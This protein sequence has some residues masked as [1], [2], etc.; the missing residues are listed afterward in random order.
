MKEGIRIYGNFIFD[1]YKLSLENLDVLRNKYVIADIICENDYYLSLFLRK[2]GLISKETFKYLDEGKK[3]TLVYDWFNDTFMISINI[4]DA[5]STIIDVCGIFH[6]QLNKLVEKETPFVTAEEY[7]VAKR[8]VSELSPENLDSANNIYD[9]V[10]NEK[11][12]IIDGFLN[13]DPEMYIDLGIY[14]NMEE[15]YKDLYRNNNEDPAYVEV[16]Y[17]YRTRFMKL[18]FGR[19]FS[20]NECCLNIFCDK[21]INYLSDLMQ[22]A[23]KSQFGYEY[24][25][26]IFGYLEEI[27]N[28]YK[29]IEEHENII[30]Q[31]K[32]RLREL[33][34]KI[35]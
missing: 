11:K 21:V 14:S 29:S 16:V 23:A 27:K 9:V 3:I 32:N 15:Y 2:I 10:V 24:T 31:C 25:N 30:N 6:S 1:D 26:K 20:N 12:N 13:C 22:N 33:G 28:I 7:L 17:N 19:K 5:C 8:G 4:P 34:E 18:L 35:D